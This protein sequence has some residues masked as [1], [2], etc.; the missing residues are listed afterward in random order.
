ML[1][2]VL[3]QSSP[4]NPLRLAIPRVF[5]PGIAAFPRRFA[6]PFPQPRFSAMPF[7]ITRYPSV[8]AQHLCVGDSLGA[9]SDAVY[10]TCVY[11]ATA[12]ETRLCFT[13]RVVSNPALW[14][15]LC[16]AESHTTHRH[17]VR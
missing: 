5:S 3:V 12:R 6:L 8:D 17:H 11:F 10:G 9:C 7:A 2:A 1:E 14:L 4:S 13:T 16:L 15:C